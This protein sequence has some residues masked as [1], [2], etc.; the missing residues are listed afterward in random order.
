MQHER[1]SGVPVVHAP[2]LVDE[3]GAPFD[4]YVTNGVT[5]DR[6]HNTGRTSVSITDAVG[7]INAVVRSRVCH[8]R[9]LT[10]AEIKFIR[11]AINAKAKDLAEAI[12]ISAEHLSRCEN[13]AATLSPQ[14]EKIFRLMAF[15]ASYST[16]PESPLTPQEDEIRTEIS[17]DEGARLRKYVEYFVAMKITAAHNGKRLSFTFTRGK[18]P[19]KE[20]DGLDGHWEKAA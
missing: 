2:Y 5:V 14:S 17:K 15:L 4:V 1:S 13:G 10:G 16:K 19:A 11:K 9:K 18:C 6:N 20:C 12:E 8:K 7:L 3:L